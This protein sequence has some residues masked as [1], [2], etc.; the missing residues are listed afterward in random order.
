MPV[1]YR[2]EERRRATQLAPEARQKLARGQR[3]CAPPL[4][5]VSNTTRPEGAK[6]LAQ[7]ESLGHETVEIE[8]DERYVW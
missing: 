3:L 4:G 6:N 7:P 1:D 5:N 2:T 8:Y